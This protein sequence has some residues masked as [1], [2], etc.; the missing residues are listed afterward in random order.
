MSM[1]IAKKLAV[2]DIL[3]RLATVF[4]LAALILGCGAIVLEVSLGTIQV[5]P[6]GDG[7]YTFISGDV[8]AVSILRTLSVLAFLLAGLIAMAQGEY[9]R[10]SAPLRAACCGCVLL[11]GIWLIA[12]YE[13]PSLRH[14]LL[15]PTSPLIWLMPL[16]L[17]AG[18]RR[19]LWPNLYPVIRLLAYAS[20]LLGL[21]SF[22]T[23]DIQ[24]YAR[25]SGLSPQ[26]IYT[27]LLF[28]FGAFLLL[29]PGD[30]G[31]NSSPARLLPL[32]VCLLLALFTQ[33]RG[34]TLLC[35]STVGIR[36]FGTTDSSNSSSKRR[37]LIWWQLAWFIILIAAGGW[38]LAERL[39]PALSGL[40][41]RLTEDS[42]SGEYVLFFSRVGVEDLILGKGPQASYDRNGEES[43]F[44]DNQ[45]LWILF[46]GGIPAL[47]CYSS[48][49][50]WPGVRPFLL[51]QPSRNRVLGWIPILWGLAMLGVSTYLNIGTSAENI[52]IILLAGKCHDDW[53]STR[54][55]LKGRRASSRAHPERSARLSSR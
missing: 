7:S 46:I 11:F 36:L 49:V 41:E 45:F 42:R 31:R 47:L 12:G 21:L 34:W 19:E 16:G 20:A 44:L 54:A 23:I 55:A 29:Q 10:L 18:M 17:F 37:I 6:G 2:L 50:L 35:I 32:V 40:K 39:S 51:R 14:V 26:I 48:L 22:F 13:V 27:S 38:F 4:T 43:Q 15:G 3:S 8:K 25:F 28:W 5:E 9:R 52:L 24:H 1:N 30:S 33:S 53:I